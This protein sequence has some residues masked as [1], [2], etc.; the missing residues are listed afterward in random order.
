MPTVIVYGF[1]FLACPS[2]FFVQ[3]LDFKLCSRFLAPIIQDLKTLGE[4]GL[5]VDESW[6]NL[7]LSR[8]YL[9]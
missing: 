1:D 3:C 4:L 5:S 2:P 7:G 6:K 8:Q 9:P